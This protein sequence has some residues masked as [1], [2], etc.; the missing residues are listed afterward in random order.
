MVMH[1]GNLG[2]SGVRVRRITSLILARQLVRPYLKN[3]VQI[4][5]LRAWLKWQNTCL[6]TRPWVRF[7]EK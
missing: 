7:P 1:A 4:K 3:K 2:Y 6:S 5:A